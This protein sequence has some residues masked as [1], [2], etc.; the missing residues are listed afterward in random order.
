M[1]LAVPIDKATGDLKA[2]GI[3]PGWHG[4]RPGA[5]MEARLGIAVALDNDANVRALGEKAFGAAPG[6]DGVVYVRL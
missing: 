6:V 2:D 4:I 3:L 5:E 1:G